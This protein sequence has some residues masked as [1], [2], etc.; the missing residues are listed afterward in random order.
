MTTPVRQTD[1]NRRQ[2][3]P[4]EE[5]T[6]I[7]QQL[8]AILDEQVAG[9]FAWLQPDGFVPVADVEE[10]DDAYL[11]EIELPGMHKKDINVEV[12]DRRL[13]VSGERVER[14][15]LGRMRRR[16][17]SWGRFQFELVLPE[18]IDRDAIEAKLS[19]GVLHLR[20]PKRQDDDEHRRIDVK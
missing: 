20:I 15:R 4:L 10:A 11:V 2:A 19:D 12:V 8:P 13:I 16:A 5:F 6:R 1:A 9:A 7:A 17:R 14:E 3:D 18:R